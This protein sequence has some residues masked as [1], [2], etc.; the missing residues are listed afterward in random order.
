MTR[1]FLVDASQHPD[2]SMAEGLIQYVDRNSF[3]F[4]TKSS[5][6]DFLG[7]E[8][9]TFDE[10]ITV[11]TCNNASCVLLPNVDSTGLSP[12]CLQQCTTIHTEKLL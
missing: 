12:S 5:Q 7:N 8:T 2:T 4:L 10:N 9:A 1:V 3:V 11:V 6:I